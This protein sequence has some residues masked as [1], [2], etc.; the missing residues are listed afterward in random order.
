MK[1]VTY[2]CPLQRV[3]LTVLAGVMLQK[4]VE[5]DRM[6][7]C[8]V[9]RQRDEGGANSAEIAA[10]FARVPVLCPALVV[11]FTRLPSPLRCP[12]LCPALKQ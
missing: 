3:V 9:P 6:G 2:K 1:P 12:A 11:L 7:L 10:A 5:Q 8:T 4:T